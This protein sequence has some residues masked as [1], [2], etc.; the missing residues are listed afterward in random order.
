M[1]TGGNATKC[2]VGHCPTLYSQF[3]V[4]FNGIKRSIVGHVW[5][6]LASNFVEEIGLSDA[7]LC[8]GQC[9]HK[10][11]ITS[12]VLHHRTPWH[13]IKKK[14]INENN[15]WGLPESSVGHCQTCQKSE[16][17]C[18]VWHLAWQVACCLARH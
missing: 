4:L 18:R 16:S 9:L 10:F 6:G 15:N 13:G 17:T 2:S 5:C 14:Y 11:K 1:A 8:C 7:M 3:W 12:G